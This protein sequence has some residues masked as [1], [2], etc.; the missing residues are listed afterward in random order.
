MA[1]LRCFIVNR[2]RGTQLTTYTVPG[3]GEAL[4]KDRLRTNTKTTGVR[5]K[6]KIL[7]PPTVPV[8]IS[9]DLTLGLAHA[10]FMKRVDLKSPDAKADEDIEQLINQSLT[11]WL[12][13]QKYDLP[14]FFGQFDSALCGFHTPTLLHRILNDYN[15]SPQLRKGVYKKRHALVTY[16]LTS[17]PHL[18]QRKRREQNTTYQGSD[19]Q[20]YSDDYDYDNQG[21][22]GSDRGEDSGA[23]DIDEDDRDG[24]PVANHSE[25]GDG[26]RDSGSAGVE[27]EGDGAQLRFD[28]SVKTALQVAM[29]K[30][31]AIDDQLQRKNSTDEITIDPFLQLL[32]KLDPQETVSQFHHWHASSS[33]LTMDPRDSRHLHQLLPRVWASENSSCMLDLLT[34]LD[35]ELLK[36]TDKEQ[37]T[38]L[39]LVARYSLDFILSAESE[40][41]LLSQIQGIFQRFPEAA[42][43]RNSSQESP[44]LHRLNTARQRNKEPTDKITA[45]LK[46]RCVACSPEQAF[47]LL[48]GEGPKIQR[49]YFNFL[50]LIRFVRHL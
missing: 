12:S 42:S 9:K 25:A 8:I 24:E 11:E 21:A 10:E 5:G 15:P 43:K 14:Q 48:H 41:R 16:L 50:H 23:E 38:V 28:D 26:E 47:Q 32:V 29:E 36:S 19:D 6:R 35:H 20:L 2:A 13:E 39:H 34:H 30:A 3:S 44:Y 49:G 1:G 17:Y 40:L 7:R 18:Y 22:S 4:K 27:F 31:M 45:Y 33:G 37:N 46:K